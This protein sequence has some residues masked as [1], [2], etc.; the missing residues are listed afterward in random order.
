MALLKGKLEM[1]YDKPIY[2]EGAV[3]KL[4]KIERFLFTHHFNILSKL[5]YYLIQVVFNCVI[6]PNVRIGKGTSVAHGVGIVIHPDTVIG[7]G[8]RIFQNVTMANPGIVVGD[9]CLIGAGAVLIGPVTL[10][11]NVKVGANTV[12]NIDV[13]SNSTVV[14][15]KCRVI[16]PKD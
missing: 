3:I 8:V 12:V 6:P 14:G 4:Y 16:L 11:D 10:G 9:G 15:A 13:P 2:G 5:I 7:N 1:N